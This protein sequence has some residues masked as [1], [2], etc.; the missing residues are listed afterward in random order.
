MKWIFI[1]FSLLTSPAWA[2]EPSEILDDPIL[3]ERARNLS[4]GLRCPICQ[5]ESIDESHADLS[6]ELRL[7]LRER[8]VAGDTDAQIM[9]YLVAR[10]GE[11]ILLKPTATGA[12]LVLWLAAPAMLLLAGGI[13][14]A[15]IRRKPRAV[16]T[17]S[18]DEQATLDKILKS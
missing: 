1:V 5:N 16:E 4:S 3:E 14:W 18:Q 8:L 13:G 10:Y 17:L 11:F 15:T 7:I 12:N 2:V 9:D 6:R